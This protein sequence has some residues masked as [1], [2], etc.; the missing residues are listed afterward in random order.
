MK[1]KHLILFF[2]TLAIDGGRL[3]SQD[4]LAKY[5]ELF[6]AASYNEA[7]NEI[8][9]I[10]SEKGSGVSSQ[11][12]S[13]QAEVNYIIYTNTG[14]QNPSYLENAA[15]AIKNSFNASDY[16]TYKTSI[17]VITGNIAREYY[18]TGV[19]EY[20]EEKYK[21][22][23]TEFFKALELFEKTKNF[24]DINKLYYLLAF[25]SK[26]VEDSDNAIKYF[27][28]LI[29]N[30]YKDEN[31]YLILSDI[32]S[33]KGDLKSSTEILL[34]SVELFRTEGSYYELIY[35]LYQTGDKD[36]AMKYIN[37]YNILNS[38]N[39]EICMIEGSIYFE[40]NQT[41]SAVT[42]FKRVL[43]HEPDNLEANYNSG[44]ILYNKGMNIMMNAEKNLYDIPD[45]YRVEKDKY[46]E[47]IKQ[48]AV[49]LEAAY[50]LDTENVNLIN[51]L[52]DIYKR[53][54]RT[55]EYD[56]LKSTLDKMK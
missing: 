41:D 20:N 16:N 7:L 8:N 49:Y 31:V 6:N 15:N 45:K 3:Y 28:V 55:A 35:T 10:V 1:Y 19:M 36:L 21:N 38:Y 26:Y 34:K 12:Y 52:L 5:N 54:Q 47:N 33:A 46:L 56:A 51:C 29:Y 50:K 11:Y 27:K 25:S 18:K 39:T 53:L 17:L 23:Q 14:K 30:Q 48:A 42:V 13:L 24:A 9:R 43:M 2:V 4:M 44:I 40:R 32:Y 37:E 22:A